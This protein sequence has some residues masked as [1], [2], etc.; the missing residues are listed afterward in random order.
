[1]AQPDATGI[2]CTTNAVT[3]R[4]AEPGAIV[5]LRPHGAGSAEVLG[6]LPAAALADAMEAGL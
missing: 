6:I 3:F 2:P 1:M 5:V 4:R